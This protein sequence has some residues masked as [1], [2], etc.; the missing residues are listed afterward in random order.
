ML[1]LLKTERISCADETSQ[2]GHADSQLRFRRF[3]SETK[4]KINA[5]HPLANKHQTN[6]KQNRKTID[7]IIPLESKKHFLDRLELV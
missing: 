5:V 2:I 3:L 1:V 6:L 7:S 4:I